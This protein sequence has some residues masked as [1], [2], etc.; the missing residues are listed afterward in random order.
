VLP[1][2]ARGRVWTSVCP[3][4]LITAESEALVEEFFI[5]RRMGAVR[6]DDLTARQAEA[7]LILEKELRAE[8]NDGQYNTGHAFEDVLDDCR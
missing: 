8:K 7:F 3:K 4:Y 2:W 6:L 1:V 5:R